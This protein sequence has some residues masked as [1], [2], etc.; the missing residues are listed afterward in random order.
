MRKPSKKKVLE[1]VKRLV[2]AGTWI[3]AIRVY[4]N[5]FDVSLKEAHDIVYQMYLESLKDV[6]SPA[7]EAPYAAQMSL[8]A[9]A[10]WVL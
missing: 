8:P 5:G 6:A 4:R 1:E 7:H 2:D 3:Q 10:T 9:T